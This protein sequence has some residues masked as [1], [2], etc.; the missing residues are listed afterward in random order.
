[1]SESA[2]K[3]D[4]GKLRYDLIPPECL[5]ELAH[6]YTIGARKYADDN[7]KNS[8]ERRR[9]EA[10]L[11]RHAEAARGGETRDPED[12]QRHLASVA[13]CAFALMWYDMQ[14]EKDDERDALRAIEEAG[15]S[16]EDHKVHLTLAQR[17]SAARRPPADP[18][19]DMLD[20]R[21]AQQQ[22]RSIP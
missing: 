22:E 19:A 2:K 3:N 7:W 14:A 21:A 15:K 9:I 13:W 12:G 11:M 17:W 8:L 5:R 10:A 20:K 16:E 1:M 6:V 4:Q 18:I